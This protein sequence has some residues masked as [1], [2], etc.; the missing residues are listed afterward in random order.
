VPS[1]VVTVA[2]IISVIS[3][4]PPGGWPV[5]DPSALEV[6][7][8]AARIMKKLSV[9]MPTPGASTAPLVARAISAV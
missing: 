8:A 6:H 4:P 9:R 3:K 2:E 7:P 1:E 5:I